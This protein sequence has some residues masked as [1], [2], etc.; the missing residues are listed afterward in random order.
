MDNV[1]A[2]C[3]SMMIQ[4]SHTA[5]ANENVIECVSPDDTYY[6]SSKFL[7]QV[8][9]LESMAREQIQQRKRVACSPLNFSLGISLEK[10][11]TAAHSTHTTS[12]T[13][14]FQLGEN[15]TPREPPTAGTEQYTYEGSEQPVNPEKSPKTT[16]G[17]PKAAEKQEIKKAKQVVQRQ[18]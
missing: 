1:K 9:K 10:E 7:E 6:C 3:I 14:Q 15:T 17:T 18:Q 4:F 5:C 2:S 12:A 13:V 8:D 11:A 16:K